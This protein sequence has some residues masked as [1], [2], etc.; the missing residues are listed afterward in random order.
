MKQ[1]E[2]NTKKDFLKILRN[3]FFSRI[4]ILSGRNSFEKSGARELLKKNIN[5]DQKSFIFLKKSK[6]PNLDE[7]LK[8]KYIFDKFKP[9]LLLAIGGG[10]VIDYAKILCS[11]KIDKTV[12][13]KNNKKQKFRF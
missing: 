2:I 8:I 10:S 4:F 3:K 7:L 1:I 9:K 5:K 12:K 13:K 11:T 6:E